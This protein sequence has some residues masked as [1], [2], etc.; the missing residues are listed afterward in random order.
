MSQ[1]EQIPAVT[2]FETVRATQTPDVDLE[3]SQN[4]IQRLT[5]GEYTRDVF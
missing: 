1:F 3:T 4:G 2:Q 5:H